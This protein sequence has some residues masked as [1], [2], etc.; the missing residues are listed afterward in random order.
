M[1]PPS[2]TSGV[3]SPRAPGNP[4]R[5]YNKVNKNVAVI[6][7]FNNKTDALTFANNASSLPDMPIVGF[8]IVT[9]GPVRLVYAIAW[10]WGIRAWIRR[11]LRF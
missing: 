2:V 6:M 8:G 5:S 7:W 3:S 1:E 4:M 11:K 10:I 9:G